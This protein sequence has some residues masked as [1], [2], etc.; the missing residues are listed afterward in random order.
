MDWVIIAAV[1]GGLQTENS[2]LTVE[3]ILQL[4]MHL[5]FQ[6]ACNLRVNHYLFSFIYLFTYTLILFF[7]YSFNAS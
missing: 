2:V 3:K 6:N 7:I 4:V 1:E 5:L